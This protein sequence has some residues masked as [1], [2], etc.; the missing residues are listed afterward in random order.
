MLGLAAPGFP[1]QPG[2]GPEYPPRA[3]ADAEQSPSPQLADFLPLPDGCCCPCVQPAAEED[4]LGA[5]RQ[6]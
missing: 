1:L 6:T 5:L 2:P 4:A 3:A